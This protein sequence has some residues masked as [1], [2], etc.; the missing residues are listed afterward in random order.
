M[1]CHL[2]HLCQINLTTIDSRFVT[3][4]FS[5]LIDHLFSSEVF[6]YLQFTIAFPVVIIQCYFK[7][8]MFMSLIKITDEKIYQVFV[9]GSS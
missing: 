9:S 6:C 2:D 1:A 4:L 8:Y 5:V 7:I 3:Q